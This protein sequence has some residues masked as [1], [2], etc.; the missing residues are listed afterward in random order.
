VLIERHPEEQ[1]LITGIYDLI[2]EMVLGKGES[3]LIASSWYPKELVKSKFLKLN[4]MHVEYV[5][6][7]FRT[8][9]TKVKNIKKYL[10]AALFNAS[11]TME[12]H[13]MSAVNHDFPQYVV[14]K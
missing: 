11:S 14:G 5:L 13:Y 10:L 3:V 6:E 9:T 2:L 4:S 8:N 7:C 12:G 1:L